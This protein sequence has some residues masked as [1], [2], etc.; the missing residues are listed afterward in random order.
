MPAGAAV[1]PALPMRCYGEPVILRR[2]KVTAVSILKL[3]AMPYPHSMWTNTGWMKW[4]I[5][6]SSPLLINLKAAR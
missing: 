5:K 6:S 2:S 1:R 3:P 4:I